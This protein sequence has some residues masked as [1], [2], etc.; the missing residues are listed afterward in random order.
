[1]LKNGKVFGKINVIDFLVILV[2]IVAV[3]AVAVFILKPK[4]GADTLI[5]KFRIEEVDKFVAEKV[6]VGDELFDDTYSLDLGHVTDIELDDSISYGGMTNGVYTVATKENY[7]SMIITGEC[8]GTKTGLGAEI[9]GKKYGVGHTFVL[10]AGDAK[11]Y[12]RV[13]DIKLKEDSEDSTKEEIVTKPETDVKISLYAAEVYDFVGEALKVGEAVKNIDRNSSIG[14][15]ENVTLG[16]SAS[17][18][19][20]EEGIKLGTK[21]NYYSVIIDCKAKGVV[22]DDGIEIDGILYSVGD[23]LSV[24]VGSSRVYLVIREIG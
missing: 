15:V 22:T 1:M 18:Y 21:E 5:M 19:E 14:T 12:L 10:R 2:L 24:R 7:Y 23:E 11:L 6:H 17:Y 3:V 9:G 13:Y 20:T 8:K 4:D 16:D